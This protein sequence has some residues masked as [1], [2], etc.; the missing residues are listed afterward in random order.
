MTDDTVTGLLAAWRAGDREAADRLMPLVYDELRRLA[1][2]R[3]AGPDQTLQTTALVHEAYL[4]LAGH[5]Q[6]AVQDRHHFFALAAKAM[7]Q[8]VVDHARR[9]AAAKRGGAVRAIA[10]DELQIP[11]DDRA[12]EMLAL[13]KALERLAALDETLSRIVELRYFA[14]LSV[15]ETADALDC[16]PRTVKRDWRK[17]RAFLYHELTTIVKTPPPARGTSGS[18]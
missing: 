5:S 12:E 1:R 6:L 15:E 10:L 14:G 11:V 8:L 9:R 13:D 3:L 18:R 7:R 4:K 2:H 17:A 16:S